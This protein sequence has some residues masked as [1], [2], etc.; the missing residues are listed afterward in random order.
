MWYVFGLSSC[1]L[2]LACV[3]IVEKYETQRRPIMD[4]VYDD[5]IEYDGDLKGKIEQVIVDKSYKPPLKC[6]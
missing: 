5:I 1:F 3:F 4:W 2:L 6:G